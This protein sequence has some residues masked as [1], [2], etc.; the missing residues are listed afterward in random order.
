MLTGGGASNAS[1]V[2]RTQSPK[3]SSSQKTRP[4]GHAVWLSEIQ[5]SQQDMIH[6]CDKREEAVSAG[7]DCLE[8]QRDVPDSVR[9]ANIPYIDPV[10]QLRW[11]HVRPPHVRTKGQFAIVAAIPFPGAALLQA[12]T[13]GLEA[14]FLHFDRPFR[15][16]GTAALHDMP[17]H[18]WRQD[19]TGNTPAHAHALSPSL[20][21]VSSRVDTSLEGVHGPLLP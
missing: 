15:N 18:C 10:E 7:N 19:E 17:I 20:C 12:G 2:F 8:L 3:W 13:Q 11:R 1:G 21:P 4:G 9:C 16:P 14:I 6:S 5:S